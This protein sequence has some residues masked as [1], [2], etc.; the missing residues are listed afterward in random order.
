VKKS[1]RQNKFAKLEIVLFYTN[2]QQKFLANNFFCVHFFQLFQPIW[3]QCKI[4]RIVDTY[5][6]KIIKQF[7]GT[8][9]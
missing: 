3:N 8:I 1:Y 4:L 7:L 6:Q 2:N 5:M 9:K